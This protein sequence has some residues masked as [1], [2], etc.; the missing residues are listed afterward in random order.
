MNF[1]VDTDICSAFL[2]GEPRVWQK[3][4]QHGGQIA[5]STIV[6][7]ELSVAARRFGN[8]SRFATGL[9]QLISHLE[10]LPFDLDC[11]RSFGDIRSELLRQGK[12]APATDMLIAATAQVH[13]LWLVTHNRAHFE[14]VADIQI[15]DWIEG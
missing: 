6:I 7:A 15:V 10:V 8:T 1:L 9:E 5:I 14:K 12:P 4:N 11:A 13:K 2:R 3:F